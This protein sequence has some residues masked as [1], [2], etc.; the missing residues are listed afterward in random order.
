MWATL[1]R[2]SGTMPLALA[3]GQGQQDEVE[4]GEVGGVVGGVAQV[5]VGRR[6]ARVRV[7]DGGAGGG[8]AGDVDDVEL[9]VAGQQPQQ[10]GAGEPRRPDDPD[11][12]P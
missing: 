7:G 6:E 9:R 12:W 5:A 10:L 1:P 4:P 2:S 8:V 11:P 3:V